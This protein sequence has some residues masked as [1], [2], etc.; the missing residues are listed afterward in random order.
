MVEDRRI[1]F[2]PGRGGTAGRRLLTLVEIV[3]V[4]AIP[5]V[6]FVWIEAPANSQPLAR[7]QDSQD[8]EFHVVA[9]IPG[10]PV[11]HGS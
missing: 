3:D 7:H 4:A 5:I 8:R 6:A 2:P 9:N 1:Q 11:L 10:I